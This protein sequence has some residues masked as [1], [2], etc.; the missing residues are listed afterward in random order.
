MVKI[1]R[2]YTRSGDKGNT[3]LVGGG[4]IAKKSSRIKAI[5]DIDEL[6]AA[7]GVVIAALEEEVA[8][9]TTEKEPNDLINGLKIIQNKLFDLGSQIA[10]PE[11]NEYQGMIKISANDT[12]DIEKWIDRET[13]QL[14]ELKSFVLPGGCLSNAYLHL[15]RTICRRA[16]RSVWELHNETAISEEIPKFLNRLSDLL[17][18]LARAECKRLKKPE[19]L[20][21]PGAENN[22]NP[23]N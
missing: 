23:K 21:R 19:N 3:G 20:W 12:T 2:V 15:A 5:G 9:T 18:V 7:L 22:L 14:E 1:N 17:F 16:E 11:N 10:T 8:I 4:R 6:N 13:D